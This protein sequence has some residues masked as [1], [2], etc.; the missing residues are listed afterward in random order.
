[1]AYVSICAIVKNESRY[2][3]EWLSYHYAIG[4]EKFVIFHNSST[5]STL[6]VIRDWPKSHEAVQIIDWPYDAPQVSAYREMLKNHRHVSEWCAFI[7]VDEFLAL[8]GSGSLHD[9]LR[10]VPEDCGGLF[11]HW[12]F[13]GSAGHTLRQPGLVTE[14]FT[15]RGP[16]NFGPN[17]NGKS[18][19]RLAAATDLISPHVIG[20]RLRVV[21][22]RGE[23]IEQ[24]N[25]GI[26][27]VACHD[28]LVLNHYFT[29]SLEEW[30]VRRALGRPALPKSHPDSIRSED[31]FRSHDVNAIVDTTAA[32]MMQRAREMFPGYSMSP[33]KDAQ[34]AAVKPAEPSIAATTDDDDAFD[35]AAIAV[36]P[37]LSRSP[38]ILARQAKLQALLSRRAGARF[39]SGA[40]VA[41]DAKVFTQQLLM[42]EGS[43][44]ASGAIVRGNVEIGANSSINAYCH[45]AGNVKIGNGC[46][47]G[48]LT[49]IYG[50]AHG[51]ARTDIPMM[52]QPVSSLGVVL[53]DDVMV[54]GNVVIMDGVEIGAHSIIVAGAMVTQ[55]CPPYSVVAGNPAQVI[56][57][58]LD[59]APES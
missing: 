19:V 11:V 30:R 31:Q 38:A 15:R 21:N 27:D 8:R 47:I 10:G 12:M 58:R 18:I 16:E 25:R 39:A 51:T 55:S 24:H 28:R 49:S 52:S 57:N 9:V 26:Q 53:H 6:D 5:D 56:G 37:W 32:E 22:T 46:R 13:Y 29:K 35:E 33:P 17:R 48:S 34:P 42:G 7:D 40:F 3:G 14:T 43:W 1:V 59:D 20:S 36:Q 54:G 2:I 44:I 41:S 45:I 4:V 23:D 50:F